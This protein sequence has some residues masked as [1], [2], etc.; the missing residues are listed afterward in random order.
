MVLKFEYDPLDNEDARGHFYHVC[1]GRIDEEELPVPPPEQPYECPRCGI[2][3]ETE[4]FW[5]A[6]QRGAV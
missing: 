2:E 1:H 3:L 6:Q 4:D 5:M